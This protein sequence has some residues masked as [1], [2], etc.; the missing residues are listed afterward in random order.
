MSGES[1]SWRTVLSVIFVIVS[2][3]RL[4]YTCS[5]MDRR[6]TNA[7]NSVDVSPYVM[8][9]DQVEAIAEQNRVNNQIIKF[10]KNK[11]SNN[12]FYSDYATLDS[13]TISEQEDYGVCKLKKDSLI[14]IDIKTQLNV[15]KEYYLQNNND[16]SLRVAFKSPRNLTIFIHDF[17]TKESVVNGLKSLKRYSNLQKLKVENDLE[18]GKVFS[19][20]ISKEGKKFNGYALGFQSKTRD[21]QTFYEFES[22]TLSKDMLK[23]K[24]LEFLLQNMKQRK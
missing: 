6:S 4:L 11:L 10:Q 19:Y 5:N 21:Y 18:M 7:Q 14:F 9:Q 23:D 16:D 13:L 3:A 1:T 15:S 24:A 20:K 12:L 8:S 17:E 2:A 22:S